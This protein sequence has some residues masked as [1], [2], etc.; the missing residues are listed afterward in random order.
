MNKQH[1]YPTSIHR[2]GAY[3]GGHKGSSYVI[4]PS[5]RKSM[6]H[7]GRVM[8]DISTDLVY[9]LPLHPT[10]LYSS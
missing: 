9:G 1:L 8:G 2:S 5:R 3:A 7:K 10:G 4:W 6:L